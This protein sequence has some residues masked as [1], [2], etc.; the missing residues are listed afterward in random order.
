MNVIE[1][2]TIL[3]LYRPGTADAEDP[4]IAVALTLAK[5][6][7]ELARWLEEHCAR[8][9]A[10]RNKFRQITAP[11]GL[12]EQIIAEQAARIV[13]IS[14]RRRNT[15]F[16]SVAAM[17]AVVILLFVLSSSWLPQRRNNDN[18]LAIYQNQMVGIALR[19]YGM[20]LT[21]NDPVQIRAYL[22]QNKGPADYTLPTA[23]Q[24]ADATGCAIEGW[25]N[26]KVSMICFRTGRPLPQ[27]QSS[28][29][30]LFVVDRASLKDAPAAGQTRF[31]A[32]NHLITAVWSKDDKVYL[33]G[34]AGDESTIRKF[35]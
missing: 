1:A 5:R 23:L 26:V 13:T 20:D 16:A 8:Q 9:N 34:T 7:P 2:K 27:N 11:A 19:G 4:Q 15:V 32:V 30:W 17:A 31:I 3:L 22:A 18:T 14:R 10:L 29:L 6:E 28:D 24:K 25:Q 33:L 21:T 12:K 35:L